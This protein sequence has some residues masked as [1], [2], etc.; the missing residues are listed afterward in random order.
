MRLRTSSTVFGLFV[1]FA[2]VLATA[3]PSEAD[4]RGGG[5]RGGSHHRGHHGGGHGGWHRGGGHHHHHH[6]HRRWYGGRW[7]SGVFIGAP[8]L[9]AAPFAYRYPAYPPVVVEPSPAPVYVEPDPPP[10]W[11]YCQSAGAYY[12]NVGACPEGWLQVAPQ[13]R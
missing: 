11:Y 9:F 5:Y 1:M 13:P 12:P 2:L 3:I 4:R 8:F 6:H 10:Y 7:K